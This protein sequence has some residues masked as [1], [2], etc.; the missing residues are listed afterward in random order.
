[1][2]QSFLFTR[3]YFYRPDT[4]TYL[5]TPLTEP[6]IVSEQPALRSSSS[7]P[8]YSRTFSVHPHG[9]PHQ[10]STF[11]E[12]NVR[13]WVDPSKG[14]LFCGLLVHLAYWVNHRRP[15]TV[16]GRTRPCYSRTQLMGTTVSSSDGF[17][18]WGCVFQ[19]DLKTVRLVGLTVV[20]S[21]W[22]WG[23]VFIGIFLI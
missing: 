13:L 11:L 9:H 12:Q 5:P 20:V 6:L 21:S 22:D 3:R 16:V 4:D 18:I 14:Y 19:L 17:R 1:M 8:S 23:Y 10:R 15:K 7:C 2:K